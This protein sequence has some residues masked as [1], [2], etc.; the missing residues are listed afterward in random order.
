MNFDQKLNVVLGLSEN[1]QTEGLRE[2]GDWVKGKIEKL[3]GYVDKAVGFGEKVGEHIGAHMKAAKDNLEKARKTKD[4]ASSIINELIE[5]LHKELGSD[6]G[7]QKTSFGWKLS[8][9]NINMNLTWHDMSRQILALSISGLTPEERK[10]LRASSS[11]ELHVIDGIEKIKSRAKQALN[12]W[13]LISSI[14]YH[15]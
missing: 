6:W 7:K 14:E 15:L 13:N 12:K 9:K 11:Y 2:V 8:Y 10:K 5:T 1:L 3:P 4:E